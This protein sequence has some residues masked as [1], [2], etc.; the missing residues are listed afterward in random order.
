[1]PSVPRWRP[2]P[3]RITATATSCSTSAPTARRRAARRPDYYR[4]C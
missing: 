4:C 2:G 1:M 3:A